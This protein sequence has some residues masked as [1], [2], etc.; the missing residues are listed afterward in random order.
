MKKIGI[1]I[2]LIIAACALVFIYVSKNKSSDNE[3]SQQSMPTQESR[4]EEQSSPLDTLDHNPQKNILLILAFQDFNDTEYKEVRNTLRSN[5]FDVITAS[6]ETGSATGIEGTRARIDIRLDKVSV[7]DYVGVVFIG[8]SGVT[9]Y[10]DDPIAQDLAQ[11][12]FD[13]GKL[14]SAICSAPVI[15]ANAGLL[16][17]KKAT[18][19]PEYEGSLTAKGAIHTGDNFTVDGLI[20][21]GKGPDEAREF[22][23]KIAELLSND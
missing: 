17:D 16:Q 9:A 23:D 7:D 6:T 11:S 3:T 19:Y 18:C 12:F 22:A 8:G 5:R 15:L 14:T 21:T 13:A 2:F 1:L 20:V 4:I 10:F